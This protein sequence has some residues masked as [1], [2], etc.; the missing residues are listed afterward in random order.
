MKV[1]GAQL[2]DIIGHFNAPVPP[3][4]EKCMSYM[5]E[6]S[7]V[8]GI[9]RVPGDDKEITRLTALI[10]ATGTI[11]I[12][13]SISPFI[14]ANVITRFFRY[15]KNHI[16]DNNFAPQWEK[17]SKPLGCKDPYNDDDLKQVSKLIGMLP[18][19]NKVLLSRI[20][21]FF[22]KISQDKRN[23]MDLYN[24]SVPLAPILI[25]DPSKPQWLLDPQLVKFI[26][27]HYTE[28]FS[29][30]LALDEKG[31]WISAED[32]QNKYGSKINEAFF[33][34]TFT[35]VPQNSP[36]ILEREL[37]MSRKI[38]IPKISWENMF[39]KLLTPDQVGYGITVK[40]LTP[41]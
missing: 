32:F 21:G 18:F 3:F 16:L 7:H 14:I 2:S 20:L 39:K 30:V 31:D 40:R 19:H 17:I 25:S 41:I 38:V 24:I 5:L 34:Q 12:T 27:D 15:L 37:K 4:L 1:Y 29:D 11:N 35:A 13:K 9:F 6:N 8:V 36:I 22:V 28:L 26:F 10:D 23:K 33:C